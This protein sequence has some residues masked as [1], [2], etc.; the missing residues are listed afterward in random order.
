MALPLLLFVLVLVLVGLAV[1]LTTSAVLGLATVAVSRRLPLWVR[2]T[3]L[4][5][6]AAGSAAAWVSVLGVW[7]LWRQGAV[8]LPFLT[9]VASGAA[10]LAL[11]ALTRRS[12]RIPAP[13]W[14]VRRPPAAGR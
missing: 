2:I 9:T 12:P 1:I 10:L 8:A 14:P 5:A 13:A 4:L 7:S 6:L 3:L 11:E